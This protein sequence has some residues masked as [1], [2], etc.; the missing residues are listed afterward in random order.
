[1]YV[2]RG[3]KNKQTYPGDNS[4]TWVGQF[5]R[6][7]K[8]DELPQ[9]INVLIGDMSLV[10]P[11]PCLPELLKELTEVGE[12]RF[13]CHPGLTGLAQVNGNIYLDWHERWEFDSKYVKNITF[14][15]DL[16]IIFKT[17]FAVVFGERIYLGC[18][19]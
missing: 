14:T 2:N 18:R 4:V 5:L 19:K 7:L 15:K 1:M 11:R 9:L 10:G 8:I 3:D 6:R 13:L 12:V 16:H 17:V